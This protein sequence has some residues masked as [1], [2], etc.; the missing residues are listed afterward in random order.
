MLAIPSV[1]DL[2]AIKE[3]AE[4]EKINPII[5]KRFPLAQTADAIAYVESGQAKGKVVLTIID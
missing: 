3:L 2:T 5:D 4:A 1:E